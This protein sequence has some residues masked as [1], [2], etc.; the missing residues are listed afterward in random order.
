MKPIYLKFPSEA[1]ANE[2][3][4]ESVPVAF[5]EAGEPTEYATRPKYVHIDT[6]GVMYEATG[7]MLTDDEGNT[8]PEMSPMDGWHVNVLLAPGEDEDA[9]TPYS[10]TP[11]SPRR[12]WA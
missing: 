8:F 12:V 3:L 9:L 4:N 11:E 1:I 6:I 5:D 7:N 10:V 2:A